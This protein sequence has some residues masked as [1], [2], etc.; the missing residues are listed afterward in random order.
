MTLM[1][2]LMVGSRVAN[3][4]VLCVYFK[5]GEHAKVEIPHIQQLP[6]TEKTYSASTLYQENTTTHILRMSA[7][8]FDFYRLYS[9]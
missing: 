6:Y 2:F 8:I 1:G 7:I 9:N 3:A 5:S 4:F